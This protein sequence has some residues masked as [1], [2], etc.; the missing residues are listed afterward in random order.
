MSTNDMNRIKEKLIIDLIN[1]RIQNIRNNGAE[2][3]W[4]ADV[5]NPG[6]ITSMK[7]FRN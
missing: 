1:Q 3:E 4:M 6:W 7:Y 5:M 2:E